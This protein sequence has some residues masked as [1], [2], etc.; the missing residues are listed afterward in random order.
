MRRGTVRCLG[1][2]YLTA[3]TCLSQ[4]LH[5]LFLL[6]TSA[7]FLCFSLH[8]ASY[9]LWGPIAVM[10]PRRVSGWSTRRADEESARRA[11]GEQPQVESSSK[12][13]RNCVMDTSS[14]PAHSTKR[15][16]DSSD[17]A[18]TLT[19][20]TRSPDQVPEAMR[21]CNE[22]TSSSTA[23]TSLSA[24]HPQF[25]V[26]LRR[27]RIYD[28]DAE[29][30]V[31]QYPI[32]WEEIQRVLKRDRASPQ[33]SSTDHQGFRD[34]VNHAENGEESTIFDAVLPK[35][36]KESWFDE[37]TIAWQKEHAWNTCIPL[38]PR[39]VPKLSPPKP[40]IAI[41]WSIESF[42]SSYADLFYLQG[43]ATSM[44]GRSYSA[45]S[46]EMYWPMVTIEGKGAKGQI[47]I[48]RLQNLHNASIMV[49]S[50]LELK[51]NVSKKTKGNELEAFYGRALVFTVE[52]TAELIQ[53]NCHW[54]V[55]GN[56]GQTSYYGRTLDS[57]SLHSP[58]FEVF[59]DARRC[60]RNVVEWGRTQAFEEMK[61]V[62]SILGATI[63]HLKFENS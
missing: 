21:M 32:N 55:E 6:I 49:N 19:P 22:P 60:V 58:K 9:T 15:K 17:E 62:I 28:A 12:G 35:F 39:L 57:W 50:I 36:F 5:T 8:S 34:R 37:P 44:H 3:H 33:P 42:E 23:V 61:K 4:R 16:R 41:G 29:R 10:S 31:K 27:R 63:P 52:L 47:R 2:K 25:G 20:Q 7:S 1:T 56:N 46:G 18:E 13:S 14:R 48:A 59:E 43:A 53:L 30:L 26:Q 11:R 40:D 38:H 24:D 51:R 54:A 45:P